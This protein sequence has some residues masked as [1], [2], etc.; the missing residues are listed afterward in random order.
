MAAS[1]PSPGKKQAVAV[2]GANG[3]TGRFVVDELLK[4]GHSVVAMG[5]DAARLAAAFEGTKVELREASIDDPR[6]FERALEGVAVI[7]NCAG[8]FLD[9][10]EAVVAAA[11][12]SRVHYLDVSAEQE[13]TLFAAPVSSG[14]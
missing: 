10:A 3:H 7:I 5:R 9:T 14:C 4:R 8:P 11:L 6:A 1:T 12:R 2:F 13:P